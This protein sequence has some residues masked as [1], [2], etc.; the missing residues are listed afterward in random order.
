MAKKKKV[1]KK[2]V[3]M[4]KDLSAG[5]HV[6][7]GVMC[8]QGK[9]WFLALISEVALYAFF[10]YLLTLLEVSGNLYVASLVLLVLVNVSVM[11]CPIFRKHYM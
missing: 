6:C 9:D 3:G 10:W 5:K 2:P 8:W 4:V 11:A 1:V 7:S